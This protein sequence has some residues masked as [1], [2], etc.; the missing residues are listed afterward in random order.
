MAFIPELLLMHS[1]D[2]V[3]VNGLGG[4]PRGHCPCGLQVPWE[5]QTGEQSR[6]TAQAPGEEGRLW[7]A[8]DSR[9]EISGSL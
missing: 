1:F 2:P 8:Q 6:G 9:A 4:E 7:G 3:L 5:P